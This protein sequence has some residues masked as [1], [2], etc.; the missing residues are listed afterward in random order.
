MTDAIV[1][2]SGGIDSATALAMTRAAGRRC[3]ALSFRYGQRHAVELE[4]AARVARALGADAHKIIDLDLRAVGGSA[5]TDDIAVPKD[6]SDAEIGGGIPVTYVPA[7]NTIFVSYAIAVAEVTGA[8]EIVVGVNVLDSSGYPDCRPEWLSA[9]QEVARL[10]T[11]AGVERR[12][13]T[14][15]APLIRMSKA[16]IIRAGVALGVD[17]SLTHSCY[18]PAPD[19]AACGGCDSCLLR[20]RGFEAAE[21]PD[22]TIYAGP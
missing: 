21:V 9:M 6:R 14:M 11:K 17:Y 13:F 1:L 20:R 22:P 10:G 18:D 19:G 16:E 4:A 8:S 3:H 2:L 12:A 5:L 15:R 7:R